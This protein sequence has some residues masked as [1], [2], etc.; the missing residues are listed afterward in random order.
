MGDRFDQATRIARLG[1]GEQLLLQHVERDLPA[2][3]K[4]TCHQGKAALLGEMI[5]GEDGADE[6]ADAILG[7]AA[8][9]RAVA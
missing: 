8:K 9:K 4:C 1:V 3:L 2:A 7:V 6:A 5:R